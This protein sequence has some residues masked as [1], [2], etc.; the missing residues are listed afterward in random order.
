MAMVAAGKWDVMKNAVMVFAPV[1]L[2]T[3]TVEQ[4]GHAL[5]LHLHPG[6]HGVWH[7]R[8]RASLGCQVTLCASVGGEV[9]TVLACLLETEGVTVRAV[10]RSEESGWYVHDRRDGQRV[11]VAEH[12]GAPMI[13]HD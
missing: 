4:Q 12:P 13:R 1:P 8:M 10:A 11:V 2:L 6:G 9:G 3:V 7:S 5:E